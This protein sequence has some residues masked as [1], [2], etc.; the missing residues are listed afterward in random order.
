[1]G[2][3]TSNTEA[4]AIKCAFDWYADEEFKVALGTNGSRRELELEHRTVRRI[5]SPRVTE[6]LHL[7]RA[8]LAKS[9]VHDVRIEEIVITGGGANLSGIEEPI[10]EFFG[11]PTRIGIPRDTATAIRG[12]SG[13][14]RVWALGLRDSTSS[15]PQSFARP[16][17]FYVGRRSVELIAFFPSI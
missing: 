6:L 2:L 15:T 8:E 12:C 14:A 7:I 16:A 4:E 13:L 9:I 10:Q 11:L 3:R 5:V 1:M 17:P